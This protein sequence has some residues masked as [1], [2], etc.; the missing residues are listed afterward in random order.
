MNNNRALIIVDYSND[1]VAPDGALTCGKPGR[2]I[3]QFIVNRIEEYNNSQDDI[4]FTMDLHY[5]ED[6][7]HP[8]NDLFPPHNIIGTSGRE[9]YGRVNDIYQRI[10]YNDFVHFLDKTRYDSFS[11]T[12]LD[13][14]LRERNIKDIEIVGVCTDICVLH[15]AVS[16][17]NLNY[18]LTIPKRG[19]A[20]FDENGHQWALN[21]FRNS[22]GAAVEQ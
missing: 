16:A 11:G 9:L 21:H 12:P 10:Q 19:V 22:L 8:E 7:A 17:Y 2:E 6:T 13:L 18:N 15:T 4:F 14:M 1:F 3:E 5:E 20:S